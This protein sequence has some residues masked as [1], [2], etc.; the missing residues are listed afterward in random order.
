MK[1]IFILL[2]LFTF[3]F[4]VNASSM[5]QEIEILENGDIKVKEA[6]SIDGKYNG[7]NL[8]LI[9]KYFDENKIYSADDIEILKICESN[10]SN[11][12]NDIGTCFTKTSN[13][14]KGD[15]LKYTEEELYNGIS[16]MLYNPSDRNKAFYV[17]YILKNIVVGHND[18]N[19]LRI[20]MLSNEFNED[21][22]NVLIKVILPNNAN[23]LRA[24]AHGPLWGNID[25][26]DEKKYVVFE[27]EDYYS[28]TAFDIRLA[29]DKNL[30]NTTKQTNKDMLNVIIEEETKKADEVNRER[31]ELKKYYEN[32]EKKN[33]TKK[34][35][36]NISMSTWIIACLIFVYKFYN[37]YDKEYKS[38]F[39]QKYYR[40]FPSNHS[41]ETI[42]YL[43]TKR[44]TTNGLSSA[45]LYI[46][47]KKGFL[48]E[49]INTKSKGLF[50]KN[51]K[52][53]KLI[54]NNDNLKEPLTENELDLR[55]WLIR[56]F[57]NDNYFILSDLKD[58]SKSEAKARKF[59]KN[60]NKWIEKSK[61]RAIDLKFY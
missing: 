2:L 9:F 4:I 23:D 13:A 56:D 54:L 33:K 57:G 59:I 1:K 10:K 61:N 34:L 43:M 27:I 11:L 28:N 52:D 8:N 5:E 58:T 38:N 17:E 19:E 36:L 14:N 48:I 46:I 7:F 53:Y 20:N 40:D 25:I 51:E 39:N 41:P 50:K 30:V 32:I 47:Y 31:K 35:F 44:I 42:E 45:L 26:D 6:I 29:F 3:P 49:E 55:D 21:L 12:L 24:W 37:K 18:I 22:D 60:Y 16:L 15:Y